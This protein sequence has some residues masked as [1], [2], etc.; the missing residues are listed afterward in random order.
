MHSNRPRPKSRR[1]SSPKPKVVDL[2]ERDHLEVER[3]RP[4][5]RLRSI[6]L[7]LGVEQI[8]EA[9]R[10]SEESGVPYQVVLRQW[11]AH[12]AAVAQRNRLKSGGTVR[13]RPS[14][15]IKRQKP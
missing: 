10:Q 1:Q 14:G 11:I 7:R 15:R 9:R 13:K 6:T 12:G 5:G 8:N 4:R 2:E 3:T